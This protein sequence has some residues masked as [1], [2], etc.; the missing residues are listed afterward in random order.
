M[1]VVQFRLRGVRGRAHALFRAESWLNGPLF[2][3]FPGL[4]TKW[5]VAADEQ[6]IYR[7][8]Y[9]Y[10][11]PERADRYARALW[12]VLARRQRP[13]LDP[14]RRRPGGPPGRRA[15]P[16]APGRAAGAAAGVDGS[17][18]SA[19]T[20]VLVVGAGPTGLGLALQ[21]ADHGASVRIVERR[22]DR[23]RPSRALMVH[24]R[25]LE[26]LRPLGVTDALLDRADT[27]PRARLHLGSRT[28]PVELAALD[29]PDTA[30][31]HL[32]LVRQMDVE[33][34]LEAALAARGISVERGT[35]FR[36]VHDGADDAVAVLD[37]TSGTERIRARAVAGCDG[38]D[39]TVRTAAGLGWRGGVYDRE[40]VLADVDLDGDLEPGVLHVVAG[41]AG[42]VFVFALGERAPWRLLATRPCVAATP[43]PGRSGT[44]GA[45][46]GAPAAAGRRR[47]RRPD[48]RAGLVER[49]PAAAP[50]GHR[51]PQRAA[52]RRRRRRACVVPGRW[53]GHEHRAAGRHQPRLEARL[54]HR[55]RRRPA[56]L[57]DS[58]DA[59]RRP[60]DERVLALTHL[61][62]WAES[63]TGR[64]A[65]LLRGRIA[66]WGA[67]LVPFLLRRR[68]LVAEGMRLLAGLDVGYRG[69]SVSATGDPPRHGRPRPGDRLPDATVTCDG[70]EVRLHALTARPGVHL[71]LDRDASEPACSH[72]LLHVHRLESWPGAGVLAVRPDGHVGCTAADARDVALTGWLRRVGLTREA[73]ARPTRERRTARSGR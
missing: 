56:S 25:T 55:R 15:R 59:E 29:L 33:S 37:G 12:W 6:G 44:A 14:P 22:T 36:S 4:V 17:R 58:Y 18:M 34:V 64:T 70:R 45:A 31:P 10:D 9:E 3:G 49:G 23:F 46:G 57:L 16:P 40:V 20:D 66:P 61:L 27:A 53:P 51:V 24:A 28:V 13:R 67:P 41:R 65:G 39:S 35:A 73:D 26:V 69:G 62:F 50:H 47:A 19:A 48:H 30:F 32:T 43:S 1:L 52:V 68:R 2:A 11:G 71:L 8:I 7:G 38:V 60:A 63:S 21:A 42:L 5:W 72:P 54:S